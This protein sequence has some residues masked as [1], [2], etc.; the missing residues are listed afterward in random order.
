MPVDLRKPGDRVETCHGTGT[1]VAKDICNDNMSWPNLP[2][3]LIWT[4]RWGVKLDR[5]HGFKDGVAYY[6]PHELTK[7]K[8]NA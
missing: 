4:G 6:W 8:P 5:P 2:P 7:E 1:I 3:R